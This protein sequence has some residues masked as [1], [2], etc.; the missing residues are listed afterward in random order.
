M[1]GDH[2]RESLEIRNIDRCDR[3][4]SIRACFKSF[5]LLVAEI[6]PVEVPI[7]KTPTVLQSPT[8]VL[9]LEKFLLT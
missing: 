5:A 3:A 7:C 1:F 2:L 9:D 4:E 6:R 8:A